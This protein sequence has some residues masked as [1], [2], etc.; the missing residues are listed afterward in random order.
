M[1]EDQMKTWEMEGKRNDVI[2]RP[3]LRTYEIVQESSEKRTEILSPRK[4]H[5]GSR[6]SSRPRKRHDIL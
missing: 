1:W 2:K 4:I 6:K 5:G 3:I